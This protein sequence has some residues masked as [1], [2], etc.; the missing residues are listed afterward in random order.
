MACYKELDELDQSQAALAG[1]ETYPKE[2][3]ENIKRDMQK[4]E[5]EASLISKMVMLVELFL[6]KEK[7]E[8]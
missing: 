5:V 6:N 7:V 2:T 4:D 3:F 8:Q 1:K